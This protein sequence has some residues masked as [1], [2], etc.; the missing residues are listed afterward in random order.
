MN[1]Y[2]N[3]FSF[4]YVDYYRITAKFSMGL[5]SPHLSENSMNSMNNSVNKDDI[6][7]SAKANLTVFV[8][9]LLNSFF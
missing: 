1:R 2:I 8:S 5:R 4:E 9:F 7:Q 3:I 6:I